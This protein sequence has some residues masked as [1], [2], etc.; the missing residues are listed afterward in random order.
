MDRSTFIIDSLK[1]A[2]GVAV[3]NIAGNALR[4]MPVNA[5][6]ISGAAS[7][8]VLVLIQLIGGNDGLSSLVPVQ[9]YDNLMQHRANITAP[10][11]KLIPLNDV[12]MWHPAL[13]P[14]AEL[15]QQGKLCIVQN[16]GYPNQNRSHFRSMDI[17][18]SASPANE[19]WSSGWVGRFLD[20]FHSTYPVGYP[21]NLFTD[22]L[23]ISIG[24]VVSDTCQGKFTNF[25]YAL[26]QLS[27]LPDLPLQP[28]HEQANNALEE[29]LRF[30]NDTSR[31]TNAYTKTVLQAAK[32]GRNLAAYPKDNELAAQLKTVA[33]LISGGLKTSVYVLTLGG[34]DTHAYQ[35][36]RNEPLKGMH[37][38]LLNT[39]ATATYAFQNDLKALYIEDK[40]LGM[41]YSEFGRQIKS[42]SANGTDHGSA[43]PLFVF[44]KNLNQTLVGTTPVIPRE[45]DNQQGV[46]MEFD[47]RDVYATVL[48]NQMG[49]NDAEIKNVLQR[50]CQTLQFLSA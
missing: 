50:N 12:L 44:G 20:A 23:A 36:E 40:V 13:Q 4:A 30:L 10:L 14:F 28:I 42:N 26:Q 32:K 29:G 43:A 21:N 19:Q 48:K 3:G 24:N 18:N 37:A 22:P 11:N 34:F 39:L 45:I 49:A 35:T 9:S 7:N 46:E 1:I 27:N 31:L 8:K 5:G 15:M 38:Q 16:V 17:W 6:V 47:F 25:S 2:A 41:T 33:R